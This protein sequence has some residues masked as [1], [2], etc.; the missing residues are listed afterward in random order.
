MERLATMTVHDLKTGF[1]HRSRPEGFQCLH[2]GRSYEQGV[3]YPVGDHLYDARRAVEDHLDREHGGPF[4]ALLGTGKEGTGLSDIQRSVVEASYE[5]LTDRQIAD[6][7][8]G[9]S[10][11]TIRNHRFLLRKRRREARAFLAIMEIL[12]EHGEHGERFI[13]FHPAMPVDDD[14]L[15]ITEA[16]A[17][18]LLDKYF[19][20][21]DLGQL[22]RFPKKEKHKL[23]ILRHVTARF[24]GG[25]RYPEREVNRI[26]GEFFEDHTTLK[27]YLVDYR[28]LARERDGSEYW[29]TDG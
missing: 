1:L 4:A 20:G 22:L 3:V 17:R 9:K 21:P 28:F 26:L 29:R 8:G 5:G 11:S 23:V 12:D 19:D 15:M 16:E 24:A 7:L 14:R 27:R 25:R 10:A 6:K 2:C 18:K 13:Q